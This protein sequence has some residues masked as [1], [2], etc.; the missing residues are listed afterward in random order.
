MEPISDVVLQFDASNGSLVNILSI[1]N[2]ELRAVD[3]GHI[4]LHQDIAIIFISFFPALPAKAR[5]EDRFTNNSMGFP[6][7]AILVFHIMLSWCVCV[8]VCMSAHT[9]VLWCVP[10]EILKH[11][12]YLDNISVR[13]IVP[14]TIARHQVGVSSIW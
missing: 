9:R 11:L 4:E 12:I 7:L 6:H 3:L 8:C 2:S 5:N 1:K 14:C 13:K 10:R